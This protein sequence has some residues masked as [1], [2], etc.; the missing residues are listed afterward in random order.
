MLTYYHQLPQETILYNI[1]YTCMETLEFDGGRYLALIFIKQV[2][3]LHG[4]NLVIFMV[5]PMEFDELR[6]TLHLITPDHA[7]RVSTSSPGRRRLAQTK[8]TDS[9]SHVAQPSS[10]FVRRLLQSTPTISP[11][12]RRDKSKFQQTISV[13][14]SSKSSSI[15]DGDRVE[16]D[17]LQPRD[18]EESTQIKARRQCT[19]EASNENDHGPVL[20][21]VANSKPVRRAVATRSFTPP[22][23]SWNRSV[24]NRI[25]DL[26]QTAINGLQRHPFLAPATTNDL[27]RAKAQC[28]RDLRES[29]GYVDPEPAAIMRFSHR[30]VIVIATLI[31]VPWG[32]LMMQMC[33]S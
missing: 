20:R 11:I 31:I 9:Q 14:T 10:P 6:H 24:W 33:A 28:L 30:L 7:T 19:S 21:A 3:G 23:I 27:T 1:P 25:G 18:C 17:T 15:P 26:L 12:E 4:I 13:E 16:T 32:L 22:H 29:L 2:F 5:D 8:S